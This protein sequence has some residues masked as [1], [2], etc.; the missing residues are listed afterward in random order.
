MMKSLVAVVLPLAVVA[1]RRIHEVADL[2]EENQRFL[3]GTNAFKQVESQIQGMDENGVIDANTVVGQVQIENYM[4]INPNEINRHLWDVCGTIESLFAFEITCECMNAPINTILT[5]ITDYACTARNPTSNNIIEYTPF[6]SGLLTIKLLAE[7][8]KFTGKICANDI[9]T[10][11]DEFSGEL[12]LGN[13]CVEAN[14]E[15]AFDIE[16]GEFSIGVTGCTIDIDAL[17]TVCSTCTP[18]EQAN[19]EPGISFSCTRI[20][21]PSTCLPF[22]IP[23]SF[24]GGSSITDQLMDSVDM[25]EIA[26]SAIADYKAEQE[27]AKKTFMCM[28]KTFMGM[29]C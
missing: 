29:G 22:S 26:E 19:G 11:L 10:F 3:Q 23:F 5:G 7:E 8:Y 9:K 4:D 16:A 15:A 24:G 13:F 27:P 14:V 28:I 25:T 20:A 18:C 2:P 1:N 21:L 17:D 6:F 12:P